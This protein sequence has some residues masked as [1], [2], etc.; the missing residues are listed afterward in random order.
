MKIRVNVEVEVDFE[1]IKNIVKEIAP[2][3]DEEALAEFDSVEK[4]DET[5]IAVKEALEALILDTLVDGFGE[6]LQKAFK[7]DAMAEVV[8]DIEATE[9]ADEETVKMD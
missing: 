3:V 7:I 6:P 5:A 8:L 2:E 9:T 4:M 1:I